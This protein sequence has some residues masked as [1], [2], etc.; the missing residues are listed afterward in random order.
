MKKSVLFIDTDMGVDDIV[1]ICMIIWSKKFDILGIS[2]VNGVS[3]VKAGVRTLARILTY[4]G[5]S[6]PLYV[7][8]NQKTQRSSVQFP[9]IDRLRAKTLVLLPDISLPNV[10]PNPRPISQLPKDLLEKNQPITML[11]LGPLSNVA[12]LLKNNNVRLFIKQIVVMGGA[13]NVPGI[14][15]PCN[16]A[17]YNFRLDPAA[18]RT[19]LESTIPIKLLPIDATKKVPAIMN[20]APKNTRRVLRSFLTQISNTVPKRPMN[21]IIRSVILNN[22]GDFQNFYDPLAAAVL[23]K[24]SIIASWSVYK[25]SVSTVRPS[26]GKV[27]IRKGKGNVSIPNDVQVKAFYTL[28]IQSLQ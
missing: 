28:M 7:G 14:V 20:S 4:L 27:L 25:L 11:C 15:P 9:F 2:V 26:L 22:S 1:A 18:A 24:P 19:V 6:T 3:P 10:Q 5:I 23:L 17:E 13:V 16:I 21:K 8:V 12:I